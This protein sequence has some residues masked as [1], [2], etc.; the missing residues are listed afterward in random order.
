MRTSLKAIALS[1][2]ATTVLGVVGC[3]SAK[4]SEDLG[5]GAPDGGGAPGIESSAMSFDPSGSD[6][7]NIP[8]L[9]T[10][11][12]PYDSSTLSADAKAKAKGNAEWMKANPNSTVQIEG[13]CDSRGSIE[14][15]LSLGERR[16]QS[17]K[18]Y[19]TGL[20]IAGSRLNII[21]YGKEK[22]LATGDSEADHARN[23]RAN[24]LPL[25]Q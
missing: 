1:I 25:G 15:N 12:F 6:S 5:A 8:G 19:M 20:G 7:G 23:R 18:S 17:V 14:Y 21:S 2:L 22:P 4:K 13:H 24:F 3:K 10:I 9:Q 11:N 16:A